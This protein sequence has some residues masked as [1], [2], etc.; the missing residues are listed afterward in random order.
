VKTI[1]LPKLHLLTKLLAM[2]ASANDGEALTAI[3][4]ANDILK[5]H[6]FTWQE[7]LSKQVGATSGNYQSAQGGSDF[8]M[9]AHEQDD[10]ASVVERTNAHIDKCLDTLRGK[11]LGKFTDWIKSIDDQWARTRYLSPDQRRPLFAAYERHAK[12]E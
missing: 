5:E 11:D 6:G 7:V 2:T 12:G 4:K 10:R 3:R 8:S 1:P 9:R